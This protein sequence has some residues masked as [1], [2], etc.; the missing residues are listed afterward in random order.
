MSTI[1]AST[2][3]T[4]AFKVT[5]DTTGVL[6]LQTGATP[7]TAVTID[8]S[9]NVGIGTSSPSSILNVKASSPIFRLESGG[10]VTSTGTAYNAIR[11]SS[12]SDV[13][14][15]GFAGLAN[16][17]QFGTTFA[18]GFIRFLT[19]SSTEAVRIDSSGNVGIGTSSPGTKLEVSAADD[20]TV[21]RFRGATYA[22]RVQ[23]KSAT[24]TIV[25]ATSFNE[26]TYQPLLIG[27]SQ[28]QF[29]IS[30]SEKMRIDSS[31]NVGIGIT[32]PRNLE[33]SRS[34]AN[35]TYGQASAQFQ[36]NIRNTDTTANNWAG[37]GF[38]QGASSLSNPVAINAQFASSTTGSLVIATSGSERLRVDASGNVGIGTSSPV[39]ALSVSGAFSF[40]AVA[41]TPA[42]GSSFFA[43]AANTLAFGTA[44]TERM[45]I[46]GSSGI[47]CINTTSA[48]GLGQPRLSLAFNGASDW[49]TNSNDTSGTSGARHQ[50]FHSSGTEVGRITTTTTATT[51]TTTSDY[52]LK[53]D[54]APMTGALA[55]VA[56]LKPVTYKWKLNNSDSD[57]FIAHEL[58]EVCPQAVTGEK[59][60]V[61]ADGNIIS[62]GIDTS[63]LVAT[64]TAAIQEQQALITQLQADVAAL[65][66]T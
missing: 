47:V 13:F 56:Q 2:T 25:D 60:A 31:G 51:Y 54:I 39:T 6:T 14:T 38:N 3:S 45:R 4:T 36:I 34:D 65:K 26:S 64:L 18:N 57:G 11:D 21:S 30:A 10:A 23:S 48:V 19:G 17:Y 24:G 59:D 5:A 41:A 40:T 58:A 9:Q 15:N 52:R 66:G 8:T 27:G 1:S 35:T 22:L 43:P 29:M 62:Q 20:V 32:S 63:F 53:Q 50:T 37:I 42:V 12:G 44:S 55:K 7:T 33:V 46:L 28:I 49:C 61:D 16:C